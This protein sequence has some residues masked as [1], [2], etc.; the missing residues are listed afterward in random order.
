MYSNDDYYISGYYNDSFL[1]KNKPFWVDKEPIMNYGYNIFCIKINE[2]DLE[3]DFL[4]I[5][6]KILDEVIKN[7]II[8]I[9]KIEKEEQE[10]SI[11]T[12]MFKYNTRKEHLKEEYG[13]FIQ[14]ECFNEVVLRDLEIKMNINEDNKINIYDGQT[15][16]KLFSLTIYKK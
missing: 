13:Y 12:K 15:E 16:K 6:L 10:Y 7:F 3:D 2:E 5:S 11:L 9:Y 8:V 4:K 14:D 1:L